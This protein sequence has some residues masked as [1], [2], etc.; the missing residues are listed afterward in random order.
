[1]TWVYGGEL[2]GCSLGE[3]GGNISEW[4]SLNCYGLYS[5][6]GINIAAYTDV[7]AK[8]GRKADK[9]Y[10]QRILINV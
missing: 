8:K 3:D 4:L 10:K 5:K 2:L 7:I 9:G 6:D 1:M